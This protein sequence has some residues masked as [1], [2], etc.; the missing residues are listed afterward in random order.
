MKNNTG[1]QFIWTVSPKLLLWFF[2]TYKHPKNRSSESVCGQ[3]HFTMATFLI[4]PSSRGPLTSCCLV[5]LPSG[6]FEPGVFR[7]CC[8]SLCK[9]GVG[10][11]RSVG[12]AHAGA[13]A[14]DVVFF[15][16]WTPPIDHGPRH[17]AL[18]IPHAGGRGLLQATQKE[19]PVLH[20]G[21]LYICLILLLFWGIG[22]H[23]RDQGP[24]DVSVGM[25][26]GDGPWRRWRTHRL[27]S[28]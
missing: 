27:T 21:N 12:G 8:H 10:E 15:R 3:I 17:G 13:P 6:H 22:I 23:V 25:R 9:I 2:L 4:L 28:A 5:H 26:W 7:S 19:P 24:W 16:G 14:G 18:Q 1:Q 20:L 11:E